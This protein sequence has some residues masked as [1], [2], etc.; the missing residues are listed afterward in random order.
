MLR[1]RKSGLPQL[2]HVLVVLYGLF[3]AGFF[4]IPHAMDGFHY[5]LWYI[6][7]VLCSLPLLARG[8]RL[9]ALDPV[10][11]AVIAYL[12]YML[13]SITWSGGLIARP[14]PIQDVYDYVKHALHLLIFLLGTK[15]L[16]EEVPLPYARMRRLVFLA[17]GIGGLAAL[18]YWYKDNPFPGSRLHG[19]TL[20]RNPNDIAFVFGAVSVWGFGYVYASRDL[21]SRSAFLAVL[22]VVMLVVLFTQSRG[23]LLAMACAAGAFWV[24]NEGRRAVGYL[25]ALL[26]AIALAYALVEPLVLGHMQGDVLRVTIWS[27]ILA[28]ASD[29]LVLGSGYLSDAAVAVGSARYNAHSAYL[30]TFRDGG[31]VGLLL[32]ATVLGLASLR[33]Y[34]LGRSSGDGTLFASL[35]FAMVCL[36]TSGDRLIDRPKELWFFFWFP[37]AMI[38]AAGPAEKVRRAK[39]VS[40]E[41]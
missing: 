40:P 39:T 15:V 3:F 18:L 38:I 10:F 22:V 12:V 29:N 24:Q 27:S 26:G 2:T 30:A 14:L 17:A 9:A 19:A 16:M 5:K 4:L 6:L 41:A 1:D 13:S 28:E 33:A 11:A 23:A 32:L 34:R 36:A 25:S 21:V 7:I 8:F 31:I 35:V 37:V 20:M